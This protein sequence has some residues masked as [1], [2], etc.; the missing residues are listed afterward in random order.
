M[1]EILERI[2][3]EGKEDIPMLRSAIPL[4]RVRSAVWLTA[5]NPVLTTLRYLR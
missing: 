5:P 4:S 2:P 1:L 3:P